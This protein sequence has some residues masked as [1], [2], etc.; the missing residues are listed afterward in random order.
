M[1]D[2]IIITPIDDF[3]HNQI[4][5]GCKINVA[6]FDDNLRIAI[7]DFIKRHGAYKLK[8]SEATLKVLTATS[9]I[10]SQNIVD[11]Y[12]DDEK[13]K[14]EITPSTELT[15]VEVKE[16]I[17]EVKEAIKEENEPPVIA[18][19]VSPVNPPVSKTEPKPGDPA[20]AATPAPPAAAEEFKNKNEKILHDF[21]TAGKVDNISKVELAKAGFDTSLASIRGCKVGKYELKKEF[22][23]P[24]YTLK[25]V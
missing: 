22:S 19:V 20:P 11:Y 10:I 13:Q 21:F 5:K 16:V 8:G 6:E 25:K 18:P 1:A 2:P 14:V 4:I 15:P 9:N 7:A 17:K 23:D 12:V 3:P 24:F